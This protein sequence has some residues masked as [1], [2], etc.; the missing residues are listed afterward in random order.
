MKTT[1]HEPLHKKK[2]VCF[3]SPGR[4]VIKGSHYERE[5][6]GERESVKGLGVYEERM[7]GW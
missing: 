2:K 6:E 4:E 5:I 3:N 1:I 7:N